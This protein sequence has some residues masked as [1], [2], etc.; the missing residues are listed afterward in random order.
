MP[1]QADCGLA[2]PP[3]PPTIALAA[4]W[5]LNALF[6]CECEIL[7]SISPLFIIVKRPLA[8]RRQPPARQKGWW[9]RLLGTGILG[10]LGQAPRNPS[11]RNGFN[12]PAGRH[13]YLSVRLSELMPSRWIRLRHSGGGL[14]F[15]SVRIHYVPFRSVPFSSAPKVICRRA[16]AKAQIRFA[17]ANRAPRQSRQSHDRSGPEGPTTQEHTEERILLLN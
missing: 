10:I 2:T 9:K 17:W 3:R 4:F 5:P 11:G 13:V 16:A 1:R 8:S 6:T 15:A 7:I 14:R 12:P